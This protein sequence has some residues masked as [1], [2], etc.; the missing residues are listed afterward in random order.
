MCEFHTQ[1]K[2]LGDGF[3]AQMTSLVDILAYALG[4]FKNHSQKGMRRVLC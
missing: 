2:E 1:F 3:A 4:F